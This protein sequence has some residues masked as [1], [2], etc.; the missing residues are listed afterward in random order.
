MVVSFYKSHRMSEQ[1]A[2]LVFEE[3]LDS[4]LV[5]RWHTY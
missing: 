2:F 1:E 3:A 4:S 5:V